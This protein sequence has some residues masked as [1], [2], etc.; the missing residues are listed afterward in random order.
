M[1]QHTRTSTEITNQSNI[2]TG[3]YLAKIISHLD[4]SF[5]GALEVTLLREQSNIMGDNAQTFIVKCAMPFFGYTPFEFMG[6][7]DSSK[8]SLDG[9]S[10]T[11]KSY[12]M[13]MI[14][15]DVGVTVLVF[16]INGDPA[17]G[18]W[19]GCVPDKF[20]NHMVPAI[21]GTTLVDLDPDDKK[22]YKTDLP[23]PVAEVNRRKNAKSDQQLNVDKIKKPVHPIADRFLEQ[24]LI[25]DDVRGVTT[26]TARRETP[27]MV[28]GISTPGP[29]DKRAGAKKSK[30]GINEKQT[31]A[32][33]PVS[34]L[35]GTTLV[36][37]DGDDRYVREKPASDGPVKY[38]DVLSGEKG[39]PTI[40]VNEYF[41]VRTRTGH[42]LLFHNTEDVIYIAN[43]RGTAWV[44]LTSN[45]KIDI[46]A[47][48]SISIH[49]KNDLNIRADRDINMEAGRNVNIKA[50]GEYQGTT[51]DDPAK[52][53]EDKKMFDANGFENGRVYIESVQ[54]MDI[55]I[56]R[57]GKIHVRNDEK[58]Q[59]NLDIKVMGN[60]RVS[61]QD[62]DA[63]PTNTNVK[64]E[65]SILEDQPEAVKGL[66]IKSYENTRITTAKQTDIK[67]GG[68][69][70]ETA[71]Q[72]HMNG[73]PAQDAEIADKIRPLQKYENLITDKT[74]KW[75]ETKYLVKDKKLN[76]IM[77]RIPM[78]EPWALHENQAPDQLT[79]KFTD[80]EGDLK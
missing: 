24:G 62:K 5:N 15:P 66:H 68:N 11:Q 7:N 59:G 29:L 72:I 37:D 17:Q 79:P 9:F 1:A 41:R 39:D 58:K 12:G 23:L 43:A 4:P 54:N 69:H 30:I 64:D 67:S 8:S 46:F 77:R 51:S 25:E 19:M 45:G 76:S 65:K 20:A 36:M 44:E 27:S 80:R 78:H 55:L 47:E 38:M 3:P 26:T 48:D 42:Q 32:T 18:Y 49:T 28:F 70:H 6:E 75:D 60:M 13:W 34:R 10:D 22:K 50:T 31:V 33:V 74:L 35:G 14:P 73:P 56:G 53:Y 63:A 71:A 57:N 16:F 40:P 2:G 52:L 21:A 61:V